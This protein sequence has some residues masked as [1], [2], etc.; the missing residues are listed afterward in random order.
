MPEKLIRPSGN[1]RK[2]LSYQKTE[3]IYEITYYFCQT[4]LQKG[5][6]TIDQMTGSTFRQT[7]YY[8]RLRGICNICEDRDKTGECG[9]SKPT[10]TAGGL[11]RLSAHTRTPAMDG[12]LCRVGGNAETGQGT[13]R[14]SLLYEPLPNTPSR[15]HRQHGDSAN[16]PGRLSAF[17]AI[18][19]TGERLCR[20]WRLL[21]KNEQSEKRA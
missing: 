7:E 10:G 8:R 20:A 21:R 12:K 16:L 5:D 4:Y 9:K 18:G 3:V 17:P 2:L 1:Y 13:Q 19:A 14:C 11:Y 15:D 6:R